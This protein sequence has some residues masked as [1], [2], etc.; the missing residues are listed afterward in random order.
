MARR[1]WQAMKAKNG[2]L[3]VLGWTS[4]TNPQPRHPC[5]LRHD[6]PVQTLTATPDVDDVWIDPRWAQLIADT[7]F[8]DTDLTTLGRKCSVS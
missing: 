4:G 6:T 2:T 5:R 3:A 8:L 1:L 7:T